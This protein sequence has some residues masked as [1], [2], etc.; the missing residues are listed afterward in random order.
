MKHKSVLEV[1]ESFLLRND[2]PWDRSTLMKSLHCTYATS[3]S[4]PVFFRRSVLDA[5]D[6]AALKVC[7]PK[8]LNVLFYNERNPTY[9]ASLL[10]ALDRY[11]SLDICRERKDTSFSLACAIVIYLA[12]FDYNAMDIFARPRV[13]SLLNKWLIPETKWRTLPS[14]AE[15]C[16]HFF[17][18]PWCALFLPDAASD[19][20]QTSPSFMGEEII[21]LLTT[22]RPLLLSRLCLEVSNDMAQVLPDNFEIS[23]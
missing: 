20:H 1:T 22:H 2:A 11:D 5:S 14:V 8:I 15:V 21:T 16:T 3:P 13:L 18:D 23:M 9:T 17:G 12:R 10:S 6:R 7:L 4:G 19:G